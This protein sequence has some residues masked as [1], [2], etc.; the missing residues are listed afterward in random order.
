[1]LKVSKTSVNIL[2]IV[3]K[4]EVF[5]LEKEN[6]EEKQNYG[7][8]FWD[9]FKYMAVAVIIAIV[10]TCF[11]APA[12]VV[13]HSMDNTLADGDYL[14]VNKTAYKVGE[15]HYNDIVVLKAPKLDGRI[16]IKRVIGLPGDEIEIKDNHVYRNGK[17]LKESYIKEDMKN[18]ADAKIKVAKE[19]VFV[20]GDNRNNSMDSRSPFV[21]TVSIKEDVIGK[22]FVR[23]L[24]FGDVKSF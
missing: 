3:N 1:M 2:T 23:L 18:N 17:E 11:V 7:L 12:K 10:I 24:P 5:D 16:L 6:R 19:N 22:V 9:Y 15:P 8:I 13:G 4:K 20:M 14:F 21:G